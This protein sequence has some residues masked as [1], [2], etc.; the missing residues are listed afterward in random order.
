MLIK[1]S[2]NPITQVRGIIAFNWENILLSVIIAVVA[3]LQFTLSSNFNY[4]PIILPVAPVTILG[5]ALAIFLGFRNN[6][7]YDRWWEARKVWG[8]IVNDSRT[9]ATMVSSFSSTYLSPDLE[10]SK[11][12]S[13]QKQVIH[14]HIAWLYAL[15]MELRNFNYWDNLCSYLDQAEIEH[16]KKIHNKPAQ[17]LHKQGMTLHEAFESKYFDSFKHVELSRMIKAFFDSQGKA[18]RI[19]KTVFPYY[20]NYFTRVFLWLFIVCLPFTLLPSMGWGAIPMSIAISFV[21]KILD[22]SGSVTE[23]PFEGRASDI[24]ISTITRNIEIDLLEMINAD[25]IPSPHAPKYT[26]WRAKYQD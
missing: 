15:K 3:Y 26:K 6:S 1:Y 18:E 19:K 25:K 17:I 8:A 4:Q 5:G 10:A 23:D 11:I 24:P 22:K 2:E 7:A 16:L 12:I 14:R 20:Y 9:F 21:F 13:W